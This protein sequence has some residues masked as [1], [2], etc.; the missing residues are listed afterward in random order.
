MLRKHLCLFLI[1]LGLSILWGCSDQPNGDKINMILSDKEGYSIENKPL[2]QKIN[3]TFSP[4]EYLSK[5]IKDRNK[6]KYHQYDTTL[7]VDSMKE[8]EKDYYITIKIKQ[9]FSE[10]NGTII[11]PSKYTLIPLYSDLFDPDVFDTFFVYYS[12]KGLED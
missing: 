7:V 9:D 10:N 2:S 11:T 3:L 12:P 1:F 4:K 5:E 6:V 8:R